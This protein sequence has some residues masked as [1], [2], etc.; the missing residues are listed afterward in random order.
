MSENK[1]RYRRKGSREYYKIIFERLHKGIRSSDYRKA[2][3]EEEEIPHTTLDE[4]LIILKEAGI[5]DLD[6]Q[7]GK[8]YYT[9]KKEKEELLKEYQ[10]Y[11]NVDE[12][13]VKLNHSK[14]L[15]K[16]VKSTI[17]PGGFSTKEAFNFMGSDDFIYFL[18]HMKT[19]YPEVYRACESL[20]FFA[21]RM[22]ENFEKLKNEL[23]EF[24]REKG[25]KLRPFPRGLPAAYYLDS[26]DKGHITAEKKI[27]NFMYGFREIPW[28]TFFV[29]EG[30]LNIF[31]LSKDLVRDLENSY[32]S[33]I[34]A[35]FCSEGKERE[36]LGGSIGNDN[37]NILW[38]STEE[39]RPIIRRVFEDGEPLRG[40]C[41]RCPKVTIGREH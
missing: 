39:F 17:D 25:L 24:A 28:G 16:N 29:L 30:Y 18:Q 10:E 2:K 37:E 12:Y 1:K 38:I 36:W 6:K 11:K 34:E 20:K 41:D 35:I 26:E 32:Q 15:L 4:L 19:G 5:A 3:S 23:E 9:W 14:N 21:L 40:I 22:M 31:I 33:S 8:W 27:R 13:L 7:D